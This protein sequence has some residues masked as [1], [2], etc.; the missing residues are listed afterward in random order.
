M[1]Q[2]HIILFSDWCRDNIALSKTLD[3]AP[4]L[5]SLGVNQSTAIDL[6][7]WFLH[8]EYLSTTSSRTAL[9]HYCQVLDDSYE[10]HNRLDSSVRISMAVAIVQ[11]CEFVDKG[12]LIRRAIAVACRAVVKE[13]ALVHDDAILDVTG[14]YF[15]KSYSGRER[16]GF[17]HLQLTATCITAE[18]LWRRAKYTRRTLADEGGECLDAHN[19]E[20]HRALLTLDPSIDTAPW[21]QDLMFKVSD[22][23][24]EYG[25]LAKEVLR[26]YR[27]ES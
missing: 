6:S 25:R 15:T 23:S 1:Y 20:Q 17:F 16:I 11:M 21:F 5:V 3:V 12:S 4:R 13:A 19:A 14:R 18:L 26:H 24:G 27:H 2:D 8:P 10:G 22:A 9:A 7:T